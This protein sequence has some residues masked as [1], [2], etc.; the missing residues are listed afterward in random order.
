MVL[1]GS[2]REKKKKKRKPYFLKKVSFPIEFWKYSKFWNADDLHHLSLK[3]N[4]Q[5]TEW[6]FGKKSN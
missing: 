3:A 4:M 6:E 5:A 1:S 2:G